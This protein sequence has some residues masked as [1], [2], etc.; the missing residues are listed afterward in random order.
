MSEPQL[1]LGMQPLEVEK[2]KKQ[3]LGGQ[4]LMETTYG[5]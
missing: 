3:I 4:R 1:E 5:V 2:N